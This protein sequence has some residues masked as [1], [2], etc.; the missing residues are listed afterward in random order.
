MVGNLRKII[1]FYIIK[2]KLHG[3]AEI[4]NLSSRV[5]KYFTRLLRSLVKYFSTLEDKFRI[6]ARPCNILYFRYP[7][8]SLRM[9]HFIL[10]SDDN[11]AK[12]RLSVLNYFLYRTRGSPKI[13]FLN[14]VVKIC[15]ASTIYKFMAYKIR[16]QGMKCKRV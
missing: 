9:I 12:I 7:Q 14:D 13:A 10:G 8:Q 1:T 16:S 4:R 6:S 11:P 2:R 15:L 3:R 5:E